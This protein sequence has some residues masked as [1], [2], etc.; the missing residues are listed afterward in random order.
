[1]T[2]RR[3]GLALLLGCLL[4]GWW[5]WP[6]AAEPEVRAP[7]VRAT[8]EPTPTPRRRRAPAASQ[9]PSQLPSDVPIATLACPLPAEALQEA[10][11]WR[12]LLQLTL[13]DG[14][15]RR[16]PL[17][18]TIRDEQR[19][20]G[21]IQVPAEYAPAEGTLDLPGWARAEVRLTAD[22][23]TVANLQRAAVL[24]GLVRTPPGVGGDRITVFGCG[25]RAE[26]DSSGGFLIE[27]DPEPCTLRAWRQD[28]LFSAFSSPIDVRPGS[29]EELI[30]D[31]DLP[32]FRMAGV[33]VGLRDTD[34]GTTVTWVAPGGPAATA[35]LQPGDVIVGLGEED[36]SGIGTD[37]VVPMATGPADTEITY[38]VLRGDEELAFT[39]TRQ[40]MDHPQ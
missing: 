3:A 25:G 37:E 31:L 24:T 23:C 4:A 39:M 38:R 34:A 17:G 5:A 26:T 6:P 9:A 2:R 20:A 13:P 8:P 10:D 1:M 7:E 33:G 16:R 29:G 18:G 14:S 22:G 28:G 27:A 19:A 21:A 40:E 12:L 15:T 35:G 11:R 36:V 30:I 32:P